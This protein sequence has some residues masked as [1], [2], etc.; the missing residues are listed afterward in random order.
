MYRCDLSV[1]FYLFFPINNYDD[2]NTEKLRQL[3]REKYEEEIDMFYSDPKT[4]VWD[5]YFE[6][7]HLPGA[8]KHVFK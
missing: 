3:V 2:M 5:I 6:H 8:V 7:T 4:I 1:N